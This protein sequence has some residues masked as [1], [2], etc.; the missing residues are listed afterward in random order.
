MS[1]TYLTN[2]P[3]INI[4]TDPIMLVNDQCRADITC[5]QCQ[6]LYQ[7]IVDIKAIEK[8]RDGDYVQNCFPSMIATQREMFV[9]GMCFKCWDAMWD[10]EVE[11]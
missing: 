9:S 10:I 8:Y 3:F 11:E 2:K 1:D 4:V 5:I 6:K 7:I